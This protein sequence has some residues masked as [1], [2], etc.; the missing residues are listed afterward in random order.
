[1]VPAAY[2]KIRKV[3]GSVL[4]AHD[5]LHRAS[6]AARGGGPRA[7]RRP[8]RGRGSGGG[9]RGRARAAVVPARRAGGREASRLGLRGRRADRR[10]AAAV[11]SGGAGQRDLGYASTLGMTMSDRAF[12][13]TRK[14]LF[15]VTRG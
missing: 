13:G 15:T 12:V 10:S 5:R 4:G 14:G 11:G 7:R 3:L 1:M 8:H 2:S 6:A 9:V